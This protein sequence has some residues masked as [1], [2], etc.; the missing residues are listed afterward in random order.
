MSKSNVVELG[1]EFDSLFQLHHDAVYRYCLRRL[2][3][4]DAEDAAAEVFTV[5]W[6]RLK[7]ARADNNRAWLFAIAY[8]VIGNHYR[9]RRRRRGLVARLAGV[10][11]EPLAEPPVEPTERAAQSSESLIPATSSRC[12]RRSWAASSIVL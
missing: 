1:A 3:T 5:A 4:L 11:Y 8:R 7:E 6:R 10:A 9:S 2:R 12:W